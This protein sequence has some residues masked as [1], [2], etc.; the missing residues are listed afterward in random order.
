MLLKLHQLGFFCA[1]V[2]EGSIAAAADKMCCVPS[3]ISTRIK[4]LESSLGV[5]L[6]NRDKQ[7]L[8]LT[9]EGRAFYPKAQQLLDQSQQCL[10]FFRHSLLQGQLQLGVLDV[11]LKGPLHQAVVE[12][13]QQHPQVQINI[14]CYSS[15]TLMEKLLQGELDIILVDGP[16]KHPALKAEFFAP[17]SLSLV[18][19]LADR[20]QFRDHASGLTL[21]S[22]GEK[23]FYHLLVRQWLSQ[24]NL[25][26]ARQSDIEDYDLI[27]SA[28]HQQ[29][30]FT[31]MPQTFIDHNPLLAGLHLF[32]LDNLPS[33]DIYLVSQAIG[34][35]ALA[36]AFYRHLTRRQYRTQPAAV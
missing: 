26:Y 20:Q 11:A 14:C 30:G 10:T 23:C 36:D 28:V 35:S 19:H 1:L 22:F 13:M 2:E 33:C 3:N 5:A 6:V 24:Q 34:Q 27:L 29:L 21:F 12:F 31:V 16:I 32:P 15:L 18:T 17:E 25:H 7:R 9:P 4:E 8:T